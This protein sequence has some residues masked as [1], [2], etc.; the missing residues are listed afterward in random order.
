MKVLAIIPARGGSKGVPRKNIMKFDGKPLLAYAIEAGMESKKISKLVV[1]TEDKE[2]AKIARNFNCEVVM[3]NSKIAGDQSQIIDT[4]LQTLDY[5]EDKNQ[6]FEAII[7]LQPTAPLRKGEDIDNAIGLLQSNSKTDA[8]ISMVK[9]EDHH[10]ARMY[11]I[12]NG[13]LD[14]LMPEYETQNRQELPELY[15]RNGCIYLVRT[16]ALKKEQSLMP[17]K[18]IPYIMDSKWAVNIDTEIDVI[19]LEQLLKKWKKQV[20]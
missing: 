19:V 5:F 9:V 11:K 17:E 10:P 4:V 14:N 1:N 12:Q 16:S 18:K 3:R 8:V 2:I 6:Y 20:S 15:L 13:I 7:L